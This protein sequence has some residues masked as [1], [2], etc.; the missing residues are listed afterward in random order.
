MT[1][2]SVLLSTHTQNRKNADA[3]DDEKNVL[4]K[5]YEFFSFFCVVFDYNVHVYVYMHIFQVYN[6]T[7]TGNS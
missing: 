3:A 4:K 6:G 5:I 1:Q 2:S 7:T